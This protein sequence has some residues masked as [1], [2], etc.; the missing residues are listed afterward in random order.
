MTRRSKPTLQQLRIGVDTGGTF[1]DFIV[2]FKHHQFSFKVPSTPRAPAQAILTGLSHALD[3]LSEL[4]GDIED[5]QTEIVHGT[6]VATN[7]L[8]ERKGARTALVTT[9]GFEDV[10]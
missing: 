7:A 1:T 2:A 8:L 6:T 9:A 5:A 10:I 4:V 3:Q